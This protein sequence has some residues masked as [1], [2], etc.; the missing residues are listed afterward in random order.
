MEEIRSPYSVRLLTPDDNS[1]MLEVIKL[2]P[3][4]SNGLSICFDR[5]PDFFI[6]TG[7]KYDP[8]NYIGIFKD[9]RLL[10]F[11]LM[12]YHTGMVSGVPQKVFHL[13]NVFMRREFRGKGLFLKFR[14]MFFQE[15]FEK[16]CP[17][18]AVIMKGNKNAERY[19]GWNSPRYSFLPHSSLLNSYDV[20]NLMI[21]FKK[22]E[23]NIPVR[24]ADSGDIPS[25]VSLLKDE[26]S[27]R[28]FAPDID[29]VKFRYN[30]QVRPD[31]YIENYYVALKEN[32]VVGTCAAWDCSSFK[33]IRI[34]KYN[35]KFK[36]IKNG[37]NLIAPL[38]RFP[39]LPVEGQP[40]RAVY[41]TDCAVKQRD[42]AIMNA[43]LRKIYNECRSKNFNLIVFGSF[44]N[45]KLLNAT[46]GFIYQSVKSN[47]YLIH[48]DGEAIESIKKNNQ[49]PYI[50]VAFL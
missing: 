11:G 7:L 26:F 15:I 48:K 2:S 49:R 10:G 12:G 23:G 1:Q 38:F 14:Q 31:F 29:E 25:I 50:D 32:E 18:Y 8:A 9:N 46:N 6:L 22:R 45:D 13:S 47:I 19:I 21:T 17:G 42:P 27:H 41:I 24:K 16:A 20:R 34:L 44:E 43:L 30:L 4:E 40:F 3:I 5:E 28:I 36:M 39:L 33:Q 35:R 37:Y